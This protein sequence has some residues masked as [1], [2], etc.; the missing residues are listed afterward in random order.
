MMFQPCEC[1]IAAFDSVQIIWHGHSFHLLY[2]YRRGAGGPCILFVH[3][4]GGAKENFYTAMQSPALPQCTLVMFDLAGTG[5]ADFDPTLN[6][7]VSALSEI[8]EMV[9]AA[10]PGPHWLAGASMRR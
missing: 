4:L 7:D 1:R 9:A 5:L 6:L 8:V 2:F 3:G 10:L